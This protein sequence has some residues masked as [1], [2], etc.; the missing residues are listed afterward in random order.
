MKNVIIIILIVVL[1]LCFAELY[2]ENDSLLTKAIDATYDLLC[3][4][5]EAIKSWFRGL[6]NGVD[7]KG[8]TNECF[9]LQ[10]KK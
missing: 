4:I 1:L 2:N 5:F 6:A 10:F 9:R 3:E 8:G 7:P